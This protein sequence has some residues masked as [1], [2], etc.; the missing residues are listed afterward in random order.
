LANGRGSASK[1]SN[2]RLTSTKVKERDGRSS[3]AILISGLMFGGGQRVALDL[4]KQ[5]TKHPELAIQLLLLG[6][7]EPSLERHAQTIV[8]YD[9]SYNSFQ[10]LTH[11]A[12]QLKAYVRSS[13]PEILH[14]HG[15]DADIIGWLATRGTQC[16]HVSHLHITPDWLF[17][18]R[19]KHKVRRWLTRRAFSPRGTRVIAVAEAVRQHWHGV[20]PQNSGKTV[21]IRNGIDVSRFRP[22]KTSRSRRPPVIGTA[23]RLVPAKGIDDLLRALDLIAEDGLKPQLRIAGDGP[24]RAEI[25]RRAKQL[26]LADRVTLLGRVQDMPAFYRSLDVFVLPSVT[27]EG[28]PLALLE[29]MATGLPVL[30]TRIGGAAEL[31]GEN[32]EGLI[33]EPGDPQGLA[34]GLRRLLT[35][36]AFRKRLGQN[37]RRRVLQDFSVER[38][39]EDVFELYRSAW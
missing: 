35:D 33:V 30:A 6:C 22:T 5:G 17:S 25:E 23:A 37:A 3:V 9:G 13:R 24:L 15:W 7:K 4:L 21:V 16:R 1:L 32:R 18:P 12:R 34:A 8:D 36:S 39:A 28:L 38:F 20:L 19:Y 29:A 31:I 11:A 10:T 27:H 26:G 14:T 2:R